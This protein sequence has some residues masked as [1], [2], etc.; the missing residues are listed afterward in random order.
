MKRTSAHKNTVHLQLPDAF[1]GQYLKEIKKKKKK[2]MF[3][4]HS[5]KSL[6]GWGL[7]CGL[8]LNAT[9]T[10]PG[11]YLGA[12]AAAG[13]RHSLRAVFSCCAPFPLKA[14]SKRLKPSLESRV[15]VFFF[16]CLGK[17]MQLLYFKIRLCHF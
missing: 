9:R 5:Q 12:D 13:A 15:S 8:V 3:L 6:S 14:N 2:H 1:A 7:L 10:F 4:S 16:F 11:T 17:E